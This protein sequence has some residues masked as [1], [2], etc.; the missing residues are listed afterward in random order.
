MQTIDLSHAI[1]QEMP[2]F[3]G[4]PQPVITHTTEHLQLAGEDVYCTESTLFFNNHLGTHMDAPAHLL[5]GGAFLGQLPPERFWGQAYIIDVQAYRDRLIPKSYL[6]QYAAEIAVSDFVLL[7]SG[8]DQYWGDQAYCTGYPRLTQEAAEYLANFDRLSGIG[9]DMQSV[10]PGDQ[11]QVVHM[12]MFRANKV[13]VE[14]LCHLEQIPGQRCPFLAF[15]LNFH[16]ADGCTVRAVALLPP[17][18]G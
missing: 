5:P 13:I 12:A 14:N 8:F 3:F 7:R 17:V 11:A 2:V 6:E 15:P 1:R 18:L 10:D 4:A 16:Q 9:V